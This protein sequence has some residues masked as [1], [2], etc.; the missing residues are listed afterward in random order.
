MPFRVMNIPAERLM[1][2]PLTAKEYWSGIPTL[3]PS[4]ESN[5]LDT[6]G[7]LS[8]IED[9]VARVENSGASGDNNDLP[10]LVSV[11]ELFQTLVQ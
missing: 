7:F 1:N 9:F 5:T 8:E 6:Q 11:Y 10:S 2:R 3:T 4:L